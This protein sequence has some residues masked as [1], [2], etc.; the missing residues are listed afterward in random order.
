MSILNQQQIYSHYKA[1]PI[2]PLSC[3]YK[4]TKTRTVCI[5]QHI[6]SYYHCCVSRLKTFRKFP[7]H[8]RCAHSIG[9]IIAMVP[10]ANHFGVWSHFNRLCTHQGGDKVR[11]LPPVVYVIVTVPETK[12]QFTLTCCKARSRSDQKSAMCSP[13]SPLLQESLSSIPR[14]SITTYSLHF[15]RDIRAYP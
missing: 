7:A 4:H 10:E 13:H 11:R 8:Y 15:Y 6:I 9:A 1:K 3:H 5:I 14:S 2:K 12:T